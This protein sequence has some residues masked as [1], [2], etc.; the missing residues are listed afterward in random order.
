MART[1][2]LATPG[3][4]E[5]ADREQREVRQKRFVQVSSSL[6]VPGLSG[7]G[8]GRSLPG[9]RQSPEQT[10]A[11]GCSSSCGAVRQDSLEA[12]GRMTKEDKPSQG[13]GASFSPES[14]AEAGSLP[15]TADLPSDP[16]IQGLTEDHRL[17]GNVIPI[18]C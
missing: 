18:A 14:G 7:Q 6:Q 17:A 12:R 8:A 2:A 9:S 13:R 16:G 10:L 4:W 15:L 1:P 11:K 3:T 5:H